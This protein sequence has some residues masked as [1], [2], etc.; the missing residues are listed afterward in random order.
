MTEHIAVVGGGTGGTVLA[1]NLAEKLV[2]EIESEGVEIT[3]FNDGPDHVY[4]PVWLYVAFGQR[5]PEDGRRPLRELVDDRVDIRQ[6]YVFNIDYEKKEL[7]LVDAIE[8]VAYDKL[9]VA[10]GSQLDPERVPGLVE[11]GHH[12]YGEDGAQALRD[13]LLTMDGGH[14]VLSVVGSPHMCP[15]APLEFVF[16]LDDWL[17][18]RGRRD[19]FELTYTY[20]IMRVHGNE[21]I[22]EWAHPR[23]EARDIAIETMF[24]AEAVDPEA[25]TIT[26]MEQT[27]LEYDLLVTIPPH[28]G[29]DLIE[30]A[31]L[32]DGGWVDVDKHTLEATGFEDI[33]AIGDAAQTGVPKAG[34]AAHY[35]AN[36]V[37]QRLA[38]EVRGQ[39]ATAVYGGKT[40]CFIETGMDDATFVEFDYERPPNPS[41]PTRAMHWSKLAYNESYWLTARGLL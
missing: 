38:S 14:V 21:H 17:R 2:P 3:L 9:V 13:E 11:G 32:G 6:D 8:P 7:E 30:E 34:S 27:E 25:Q 26:S 4:K 1:N 5:E 39:P 23:L 35:Q 37:A 19:D 18:E 36:V 24:N 40:I 12:F 41:E 16:M 28:T 15:A 20:P 31:G 33:Y 22:A 10:T 29:S